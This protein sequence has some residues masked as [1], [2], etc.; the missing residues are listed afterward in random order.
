MR[1]TLRRAEWAALVHEVRDRYRETTPAGLLERIED[2]LRQ[3][4]AGWTDQPCAL[5]LD[6]ASAAVVTSVMD[7]LRGEPAAAAQQ[8]QTASSLAEAAAL[9]HTHQQ[10]PGQTT[11][12]YRIEHRTGEAT[13]IVGWTS[14]AH[15][16]QEDLSRHAARLIAAGATGELVLVEA[17]TGTDVAR[18]FLRP[19]AA[20]PR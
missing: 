20:P 9:I 14:D 2:L 6:P 1:L 18:R 7:A 5:E 8:A 3:T 11:P 19:D 10:P 13:H 4:P 16:R 12:A 15:A 17:A